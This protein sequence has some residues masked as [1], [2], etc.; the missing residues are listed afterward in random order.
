MRKTRADKM[1]ASASDQQGLHVF[2]HAGLVADMVRLEK[3][4]AIAK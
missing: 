3:R 1:S 2:G 4:P